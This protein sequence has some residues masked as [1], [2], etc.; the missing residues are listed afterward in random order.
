MS[1]HTC[2]EW[3]MRESA[4]GHGK[5]CAACGKHTDASKATLET[6][7]A[8]VLAAS[9]AEHSVKKAEQMNTDYPHFWCSCGV[10]TIGRGKFPEHVR[11]ASA[12][13]LAPVIR[14]QEAEAWDKG[15]QRGLRIADYDYGANP[16]FPDLTNPYRSN[17]E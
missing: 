12:A 3:Q 1:T 17:D 14:E 13:A 6:R 4:T 8:E 7:I 15:K 5:Y 9:D 2:E 11:Q 16:V 10:Q